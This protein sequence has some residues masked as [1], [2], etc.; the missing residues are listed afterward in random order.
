MGLGGHVLWTAVIRNL[1][2]QDGRP[3]RVCLTPQLSDVLAGAVHR[4]DVSLREDPVFR[5]NPRIEFLAPRD[6]TPLAKS[7]DRVFEGVLRIPAARQVYE[8]AV[9]A[10][11]DWRGRREGRRYAHVDMRRHSYVA[12]ERRDRMVWKSGGHIVDIILRSFDA[13]GTTHQG[14]LHF[15]AEEEATAARN[16]V[17]F[18]LTR[19]FVVVEP[20]SKEDWF[21]D[22]R[23]WPFER[24][25][26]AIDRVRAVHGGEYTLVQMGEGGRP[27]VR[28][29]LDLSGQL[30][31]RESAALLKQAS[32]FLGQEGGLMHVADAI[33]VPSVIIWG[34]LTLPEFACYPERHTILCA[35]VPCAPCG[36]RGGCPFEKRCLTEIHTD[37]VTGAVDHILGREAAT[38]RA[39]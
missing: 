2:E 10:A 17:R 8:R 19:K 6:K 38:L 30:P 35:R 24:W 36:L 32:L 31:F 20:H 4:R 39:E 3:V 26:Q 29:I 22:L 23:A 18:G 25:Q 13:R 28:G 27:A 14:E 37:T 5:H 21:G 15:T 12:R 1:H 34:G 11:A 33:G 7:L 16:R 9:Y